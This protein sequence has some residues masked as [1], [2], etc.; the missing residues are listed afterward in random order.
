[1]PLPRLEVIKA[2]CRR[3]GRWL[4]KHLDAEV[5]AGRLLW[6]RGQNGRGKTSLLRLLSGLATP[7]E[8]RILWG[9][10]PVAKAPGYLQRLVYVGHTN[11]LKDDL[12]VAEAL[13]FL[14]R[15]HGRPHAPGA[16]RAALA[17]LGLE[18]RPD[19]PVRT[20]SQGQRRRVALARLA[21]DDGP[22]VWVLDEPF[23]S[24]DADSAER[25]SGLMREHAARGGR[26]ILTSHRAA[27]WNGAPLRMDE[28]ALDPSH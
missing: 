3:G 16:V 17:T 13:S 8:G 21:A 6:V 15:V 14:L 22:S 7:D 26:V 9:G 24:L 2:S 23:D 28:L 20:L 25:V 10:V 5:G 11:A 1:M 19:A 18:C 4:F 27:T 12:S